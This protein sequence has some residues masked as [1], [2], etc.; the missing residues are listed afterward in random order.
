MPT[1]PRRRRAALAALLLAATLA[2]VAGPVAADPEIHVAFTAR[3]AED[4]AD[5]EGGTQT[6][7][8]VEHF[9]L[10]V[11]IGGEGSRALVTSDPTDATAPRSTV[12][13]AIAPGVN[14]TAEEISE[15]T[16]LSVI[17]HED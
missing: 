2:T 11:A 9:S 8:D 4:V 12:A 6:F 13:A 5:F 14:A 15:G 1:A 3:I 10:S 16:G 7:S 17:F